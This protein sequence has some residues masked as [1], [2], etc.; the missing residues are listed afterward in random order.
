MLQQMT[1]L[2]TIA[3]RESQVYPLIMIDF[4]ARN[5]PS[6]DDVD[7]ETE[8]ASCTGSVGSFRL[9]KRH[10]RRK[11]KLGKKD[12]ILRQVNINFLQM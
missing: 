2:K 5:T 7:P 9:G 4:A 6:T 11:D 12:N 1:F 10:A 8:S 3:N